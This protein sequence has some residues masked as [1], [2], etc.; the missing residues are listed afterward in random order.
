MKN[1]NLFSKIGRIIEEIQRIDKENPTGPDE[2]TDPRIV[3]LLDE[4]VKTINELD[5]IIRE[6]F[7]NDYATLSHWDKITQIHDGPPEDDS[8][9]AKS[10]SP[11]KK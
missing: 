3:A 6:T 4:G 1:D 8:T 9:Q 2:E 7:R 10:T 5:P 11:S